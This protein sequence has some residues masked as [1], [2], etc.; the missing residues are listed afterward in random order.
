MAS[1]RE[2]SGACI[3]DA[4]GAPGALPWMNGDDIFGTTVLDG[5]ETTANDDTEAGA[6][7]SQNSVTAWCRCS[8]FGFAIPDGA[9]I[10]GFKVY[11]RERR[12]AATGVA[13]AHTTVKMMK[14]GASVG[15]D[16][17]ADG[18]WPTT[19]TEVT[20]G[21]ATELGGESWTA[22][23]VNDA[24]FGVGVSVT[25]VSSMGTAISLNHYAD[26][27]EIEV[28]YTEA[29]EARRLINDGMVQSTRLG[30]LVA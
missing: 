19:E 24:D 2:A 8:G 7:I 23:D 14:N 11:V 29:S 6:Q 21:S 22:D 12:D 10:N 26:L 25:G 1:V 28:F 30:A 27:V 20:Y 18:A 4:T 9:T 13:T 16:I 17:G 5:T 15:N 3:S